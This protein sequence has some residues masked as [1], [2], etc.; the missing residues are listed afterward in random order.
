VGIQPAPRYAVRARRESVSQFAPA[1]ERYFEVACLPEAALT[2]REVRGDAS[3]FNAHGELIL[4]ILVL[5]CQMGPS[6]LAVV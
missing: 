6:G 4:K 3:E 5:D 1:E 2:Q